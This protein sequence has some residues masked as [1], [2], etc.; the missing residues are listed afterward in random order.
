LT[1]RN[2][3]LGWVPSACASTRL[4]E[5]CLSPWRMLLSRLQ[6]LLRSRNCA[7]SAPIFDRTSR[8][9]RYFSPPIPPTTT[10]ENP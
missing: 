8:F 3:Q 1:V 7:S 4:P 10:I 6:G 2:G 9:E 5:V